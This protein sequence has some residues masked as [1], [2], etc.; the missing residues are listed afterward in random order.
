MQRE[1]DASAADKRERRAISPHESGVIV[2]YVT[3]FR[4]RI[5]RNLAVLGAANARMLTTSAPTARCEFAVTIVN[6]PGH[7][8]KRTLLLCT[9]RTF[10]FCGDTIAVAIC[11]TSTAVVRYSV[12]VGNNSVPR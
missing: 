4:E 10:S 5:L 11:A 6:A 12:L 2:S 9:N 1:G 8:E 3:C 7:R